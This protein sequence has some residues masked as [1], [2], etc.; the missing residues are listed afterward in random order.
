MLIVW[1][2]ICFNM[3]GM[4]L[5]GPVFLALGV[6]L[7]V[8]PIDGLRT[9]GRPVRTSFDKVLWTSQSAVLAVGGVMFAVWHVRQMRREKWT[10]PLFPGCRSYVT[11]VDGHSLFDWPVTAAVENGIVFVLHAR[12]AAC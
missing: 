12:A 5:L 9:N 4:S 10:T 3:W 1:E 6:A 7:F 11:P 2:L 8:F